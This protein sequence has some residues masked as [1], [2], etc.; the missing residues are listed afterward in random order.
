[1]LTQQK[2]QPLKRQLLGSR[3]PS[4]DR[5]PSTCAIMVVTDESLGALHQQLSNPQYP[6]ALYHLLSIMLV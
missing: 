4:A 5:R 1:M 2:E 6:I 3:R